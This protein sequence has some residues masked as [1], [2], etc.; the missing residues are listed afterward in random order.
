[1]PSPPTPIPPPRRQRSAG[2]PPLALGALTHLCPF[3]Q[4]AAPAAE[5][6]RSRA[7]GRSAHG[8][9]QLS[10]GR[11]RQEGLPDPP[12]RT[13][14]TDAAGASPGPNGGRRPSSLIGSRLYWFLWTGTAR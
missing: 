9:G 12:Q 14:R 8:W 4:R 7:G 5:A 13:T 10:G 11:H 2:A 6:E 3:V 1:M